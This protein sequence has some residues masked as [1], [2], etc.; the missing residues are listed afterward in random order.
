MAGC[1]SC[2]TPHNFVGKYLVKAS[3]GFWHSF[4]FTTGGYPDN[5]QIRPQSRDIAEQ[6][7]RTCHRE[8]VGA[9]EATHPQSQGG[10]IACLQCH[11]SVGHLH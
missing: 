11:S 5:I 4:F 8:I 6:A 2:H 7:C 9:I 3:N 1:N 10:Q